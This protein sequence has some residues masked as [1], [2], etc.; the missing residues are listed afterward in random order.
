MAGERCA[1]LE[2]ASCTAGRAGQDGQDGMG[3]HCPGHLM[4]PLHRSR[5]CP[6]GRAGSQNQGTGRSCLALL[7]LRAGPSAH[8][9]AVVLLRH[10]L[11]RSDRPLHELHEVLIEQL[12]R[13]LSAVG[14]GKDGVDAVFGTGTAPGLQRKGQMLRSA[15]EG[16]GRPLLPPHTTPRGWIHPPHPTAPR[17]GDALPGAG[18]IPRE[19]P[20]GVGCES[21]PRPTPVALGR[22]G[23]LPPPW[24]REEHLEGAQ[25]ATCTMAISLVISP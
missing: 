2:S 18:L 19:L 17:Q 22:S 11:H 16:H 15:E 14:F 13:D 4:P 24:S 7:V 9:E 23:R 3:M 12:T 25:A 8:L 10:G 6:K 1:V 21:P 5:C 20:A